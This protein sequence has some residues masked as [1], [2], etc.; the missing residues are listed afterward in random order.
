MD[1]PKLRVSCGALLRPCMWY[2]GSNLDSQLDYTQNQLKLI[3][4]GLSMKDF[5]DCII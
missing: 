5:I 2:D 1:H 4:L 3:P